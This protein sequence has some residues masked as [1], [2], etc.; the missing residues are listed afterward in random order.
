MGSRVNVCSATILDNPASFSSEFKLEITFEAFERLPHG[1][2]TSNRYNI[3]S[4]LCFRSNNVPDLEWELVY[5]GSGEST[6]Y[7]QILDSVLVGPT[8]EGKHKFLFT[9]RLVNIVFLSIYTYRLPEPTQRRFPKLTSS[10][11]PSCFSS[12]VTTIRY[13]SCLVKSLISVFRSFLTL[14]GL[15]PTNTRTKS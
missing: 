14:V 5:V 4:V 1:L 11:S 15:F 8:E 13:I 7:D 10:E 9:V 6:E 12:V 2:S 3:V